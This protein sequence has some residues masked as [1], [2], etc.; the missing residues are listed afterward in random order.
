MK[1]LDIV[2][3]S[4]ALVFFV[5]GLHQLFV[6]GIE[7]SYPIFMLSILLLLV[8]NYFKRKAKNED[9]KSDTDKK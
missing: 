4:F 3:L 1:L 5:I 6:N 8:L 7:A 9:K 2:L